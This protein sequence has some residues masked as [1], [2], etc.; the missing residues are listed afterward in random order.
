VGRAKTEDNLLGGNTAIAQF[1][2]NTG[3]GIVALNPDAILY[4]FNVNWGSMEIALF[5]PATVNR[6]AEL[7]IKN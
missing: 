7:K 5:R 3:I 1:D 2:S 4:N 6:F